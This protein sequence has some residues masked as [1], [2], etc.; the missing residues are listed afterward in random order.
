MIAVGGEN[1]IDLVARNQRDG[2][3][4]EFIAA[5]G[6]GPFN[7][8]M[9]AGRLGVDVSYLTP[10][11]SDRFGDLLS[12]R[13][14]QS[15]VTIAGARVEQPTS[16]AVVS[17]DANGLPSYGFYRNGTAERQVN[18]QTL[19]RTMPQETAI[20][21][22]GGVALIDG[23]DAEAWKQHFK[24]CKAN[25]ILTSLDPNIRPA[26]VSDWDSYGER[27]RQ[28]MAVADIVKLSDEDIVW[29]YPDRPLEQALAECRADCN[30]AL[31]IL[32]LGADGARGFVTAGEV[33]VPA[34]QTDQ[35]ID[36]VGAGD[37]FMASILAWIIETG[38]DDLR[39]LDATD[40]ESLT[41]S[42]ARAATAAALNCEQSGCNPPWR[43]QLD[44]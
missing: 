22:V 5:E 20:F 11:S 13:L 44:G 42:L 35:I 18:A 1:L 33:H 39:S 8:A 10:I 25:A 27:L 21:H 9:A 12:D 17:V 38:R 29:L 40:T 30:A 36:T 2:E 31:F 43:D 6:G 4:S 28:M 7:V 15:H 23:D 37:T 32:T 19:A 16:L 24:D 34:A 26:L 3:Q 14:L 41:A